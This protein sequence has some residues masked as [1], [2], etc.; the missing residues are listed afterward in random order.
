LLLI[1]T[2]TIPTLLPIPDAPK[3]IMTY[4]F[5]E[6]SGGTHIEIHVAKP[7]P[8]D[9]AFLEKD[10]AEFQKNITSEVA[11]LRL[12]LEGQKG[13]SAVVE[14]PTLPVSAERFLTQPGASLSEKQGPVFSTTAKSIVSLHRK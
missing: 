5:L 9:K 2:I 12:M 4:A 1:E 13:T 11:T 8:K 10:G 6:S 7:K 3:V 14:E